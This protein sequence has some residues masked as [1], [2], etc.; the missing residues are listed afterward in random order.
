MALRTNTKRTYQTHANT[1]LAFCNQTGVDPYQQMTPQQ[2]VSLMVFF[3]QGHKV[4]TLPSFLSGVSHFLE[5]QA[6][7]P[8]LS[9]PGG[10]LS[11][12]YCK[13]VRKGLT[14]YYSLTEHTDPKLPLGF[15]ELEI[16]SD[17]IDL[18]TFEGTRD[19][20]AYLISFFALLRRSEILDRRLTFQH[21]KVLGSPLGLSIEVAFSKTNLQ[22]V[23]VY[24]A[25][26][27]DM[28]CPVAAFLRY[29][30]KVPFALHRIPSCPVFLATPTHTRVVD[31]KSM[32]STL[33]RRLATMGLS[34]DRYGWHSWRRGGTT[35]MFV[36][37][38]DET[39]IQHHGR[40][41]SLTYRI[42]LDTSV[43]AEHAMRVTQ[44]LPSRPRAGVVAPSS[45]SSSSYNRR[46]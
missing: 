8:R 7:L 31:H 19:W 5:Q 20:A 14:N 2:C 28:F 30:A 1:F 37:G 45:S 44:R 33:K 6:G 25:S 17:S 39:L 9:A 46:Q 36:A 35:A 32:L 11:H 41:A 24:I 12:P 43:S 42:Y 26:R 13:A 22:P 4:T 10:L 29:K 38:I 18:R 34:A 3:V 40:W 15:E 23:T 16:L 21:I 27:T